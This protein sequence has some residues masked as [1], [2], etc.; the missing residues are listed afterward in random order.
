M[1]KILPLA[2]LLLITSCQQNQNENVMY[3]IGMVEEEMMPMARKSVNQP[4]PTAADNLETQEVDKKK[5]IKDGRLS[6]NVSDL[7]KS[8]SRVDTLVKK[9]GGYYSNE[10]YYTTDQEAIFNLNIR[11]P[12]ARFEFFIAEVES[13]E[14]EILFKGIDARDVTDQ[15]IDLETRLGSKR[16]YLIRYRE[17]LQRAQSV[18]D[19]LEIQEKI[20][21]LEEEIESTT[22]R[23]K[24]L[25]DLVDFSS[26]NLTLTQQKDFKYTPARRDSFSERLKQ[27]LMRGWYGF[28]DFLLFLVKIWPLWILAAVMMVLW[29]NTRRK[30]KI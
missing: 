15:F 13:G 20:R 8:K 3:D 7:Q 28:V 16:N 5:I 18:K 21:V 23:L 1:N 4:A 29:K 10:N 9:H 12:S 30:N 24:Y 22:G 2:L 27:A 19:I 6:L 17:L 14:G 25:S 11:I 26:L